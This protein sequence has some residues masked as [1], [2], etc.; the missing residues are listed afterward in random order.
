[1][2]GCGRSLTAPHVAPTSLSSNVYAYS[3]QP[4]YPQ[5]PYAPKIMDPDTQKL[6]EA[7]RNSSNKPATKRP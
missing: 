1:M 6:M 5:Q 7:L 3:P 4:N 2:C